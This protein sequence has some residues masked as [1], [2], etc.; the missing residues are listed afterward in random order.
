MEES[1]SLPM[2][3]A[4]T[5]STIE[6]SFFLTAI[7]SSMLLRMPVT[8]TSSI[9]EPAPAAGGCSCA[10]A[11]PLLAMRSTAQL[12]AELT[13]HCARRWV[14]LVRLPFLVEVFTRSPFLTQARE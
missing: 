9:C 12:V 2:S 5:T 4:D 3:S 11:A 8:I 6:S 14:D 7:E 1:G 10:R 13:S